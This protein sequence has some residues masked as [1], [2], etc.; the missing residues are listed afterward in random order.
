MAGGHACRAREYHAD[1]LSTARLSAGTAMKKPV[2][3]QE[4]DDNAPEEYDFSRGRRGVY[5][6]WYQR[7]KGRFRLVTD[8]EDR[9]RQGEAKARNPTER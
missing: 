2:P 6:E 3:N 9:L 7:A 8:D 1:H 4:P 5:Y